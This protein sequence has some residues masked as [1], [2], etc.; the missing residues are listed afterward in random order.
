MSATEAAKILD[1]SD[2]QVRVLAENGQ[3][4]GKKT[5]NGPWEFSRSNVLQFKRLPRPGSGQATGR[6]RPRGSKS[7]SPA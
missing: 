7:K 4:I 3:L 5:G 6:G 1:L 2:R